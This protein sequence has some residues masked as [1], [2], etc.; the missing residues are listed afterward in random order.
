MSEPTATAR[1]GLQE[2][3]QISAGET[4]RLFR[5]AI[6]WVRPLRGRFLFKAL[7]V[8]ISVL[9]MLFLPFPI[10]IFTDHVILAMPIA[11]ALD[12]YPP[13]LH[14]IVS[15]MAAGA[16]AEIA[17]RTAG[18]QLVTLVLFGAFGV[19]LRE[20]DTADA[21]VAQGQ[22]TATQTENDANVGFTLG[23][24]LLGLLDYHFTLRLSQ[25]LNHLYRSRLFERIQT[26]PM[27]A[28]DDERIGDAVYRVMY[29]TP[30]ITQVCYRMILTPIAAPIGILLMAW[31]LATLF[32]DDPWIVWS[33]MA[34]LPLTL[35]VTIPFSAVYRN[36]GE[37][38]RLAGSGTTST[39]EEG[40]QNILAVQSLGAEALQRKRFDADSDR[41][42]AEY[43]GMVRVV[44]GAIFVA[45]LA[46]GA[47]GIVLFL[48]MIDE[49][50]AGNL[51]PGDL[52]LLTTFYTQ[53]AFMAFELG[54]AWFLSQSSA[55]GLHRVSFLM[56]LAGEE[57][58]QGMPP[59]APLREGLRFEGV[60]FRYG[61]AQA[62]EN[63]DFE[64]PLGSFTAFV[65]P[66]GAGKTT[67]AYMIPRFLE[68]D[69]GRILADGVDVREATRASLRDQVAFVFQETQL[70]DATVEENLRI[71]NPEASDAELRRAARVAGADRFIEA[72]P[73]GYRTPLGRGG[74]RLSTGQKQRLAIARALLRDAP[75]LIL[76]EPTSA[77]DPET[78]HALV[79]ALR[80]ASRTKLV[81]VIAHRLSSIRAA[82]QILFLEEGRILERGS[83]EELIAREG[84]AY[85]RFVDLQT[86]GAA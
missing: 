62:L 26:L 53:M 15:W 78:E 1:P 56:K 61:N 57:D 60:G 6:S 19:T 29:D 65:G 64:A 27:R 69:A 68:P 52:T 11:G 37:R 46:G 2:S 44:M 47:A 59:L 48:H 70:F 10:K 8:V 7:V 75:I 12:Q 17:M 80:E 20:R 30:A 16:P 36:R 54:G 5:E 9:P 83:H 79:A 86:R 58:P 74:G 23:G 45:V 82:D 85:R 51:T 55:S 77:L 73:E 81:I 33:A 32:G 24:G 50:I 25:D 35:L 3:T 34:V 49:V 4:V 40:V 76:D 28:F 84:G 63:V 21:N 31:M 18:V 67:L 43:R 22:D 14:G 72:L 71:G 39:L 38:S 41:S 42:F 13:F 66:A